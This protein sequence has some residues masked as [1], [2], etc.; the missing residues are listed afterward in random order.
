MVA[1]SGDSEFLIAALRVELSICGMNNVEF[2]AFG[3]VGL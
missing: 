3:G 2:R 1:L